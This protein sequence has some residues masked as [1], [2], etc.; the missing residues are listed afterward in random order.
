MES[1]LN[2]GHKNPNPTHPKASA[3]ATARPQQTCTRSWPIHCHFCLHT[4]HVHKFTTH[5]HSVNQSLSIVSIYFHSSIKSLTTS[6]IDIYMYCI[7]IIFGILHVA[8]HIPLTIIKVSSTKP[9]PSCHTK[10]TRS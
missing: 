6:D 8:D 9:P 3:T 4:S 10:T 2:N 7:K 5:S 1:C